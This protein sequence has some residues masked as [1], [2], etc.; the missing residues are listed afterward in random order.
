MPSQLSVESGKWHRQFAKLFY[1]LKRFMRLCTSMHKN[2]RTK[3]FIDKSSKMLH[4]CYLFNF[5]LYIIKY[6]FFCA[7]ICV[8]LLFFDSNVSRIFLLIEQIIFLLLFSQLD[9][10]FICDKSVHFINK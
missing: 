6:L 10:A 5:V 8:Y 2:G 1:A 9:Y 4:D 7:N 3:H